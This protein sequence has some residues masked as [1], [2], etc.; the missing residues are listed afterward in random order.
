MD[1]SN[2]HNEREKGKSYCKSGNNLIYFIEFSEV[3][4][5]ESTTY[6]EITVKD[7]RGPKIILTD[8]NQSRIN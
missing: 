2:S 6:V 4:D 7:E 8:C 3:S 1:S 5:Y